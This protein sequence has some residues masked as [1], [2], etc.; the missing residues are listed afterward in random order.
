MVF[1][2]MVRFIAASQAL[3]PVFDITENGT[4]VTSAIDS[5]VRTFRQGHDVPLGIAEILRGKIIRPQPGEEITVV[6]FFIPLK[7]SVWVFGEFDGNDTVTYGEGGAG[8]YIS[9]MDPEME[10]A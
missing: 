5:R 10:R 1:D 7:K 6:E 4:S 9:Y 8:L 3:V 2:D